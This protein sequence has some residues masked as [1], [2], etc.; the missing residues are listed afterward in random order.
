MAFTKTPMT[1]EQRRE[2]KRANSRSDYHRN[3]EKRRASQN[4]RKRADPEKTAAQ[5]RGYR[6]AAPEK[7][8]AY[9][10]KEQAIRREKYP[11]LAAFHSRRKHAGKRGLPFT[12]TTEWCRE[13]YTGFCSL[14]GI[15]FDVRAADQPGNPGPRP[16]SISIDKVDQKAGYII[17]NCR[18][19]LNCL[20]TMRG[21]GSDDEMMAV[22]NA[23][24]AKFQPDA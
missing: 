9:G 12:I 21:S 23:L 1:E 18:F 20:N 4:A 14:T 22:A 13:T 6:A 17:G 5:R 7:Y 15:P 16:H 8:K 19:I 2:K 3:I 11:W 10:R 24:I